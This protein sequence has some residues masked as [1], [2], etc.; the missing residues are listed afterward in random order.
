LRRT[1]SFDDHAD[2]KAIAQ[3]SQSHN[4]QLRALVEAFVL[5]DLFQKR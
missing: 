5:S 3:E 2:L 4:Y 1:M